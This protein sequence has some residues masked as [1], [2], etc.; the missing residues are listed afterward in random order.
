[1]EK[2]TEKIGTELVKAVEK[3]K[4]AGKETSV[5]KGEV[6]ENKEVKEPKPN[7]SQKKQDKAAELQADIE[8]KT[9]ELQ[10]CLAELERK[11]ELSRNRTAFIDALEKLEDASA[12]IKEEQAFDS[13]VYKLRFVDGGAYNSNEIF[14]ISNRYII[15]EFV[16][17]IQNRIAK[18]IEEIELRLIS[19]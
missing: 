16:A 15:E 3:M 1:M 4:E 2:Q 11:K 5:Q 18:K 6:K 19:E 13:R 14:S 8:R 9:K 17:F 12:K 10:K 7:K